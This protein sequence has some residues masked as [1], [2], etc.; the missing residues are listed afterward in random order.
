V[1]QLQGLQ[2]FV[3][4]A[5]LSCHG[6]LTPSGVLLIRVF[7][8][9]G[10][11]LYCGACVRSALGIGRQRIAC[12]RQIKQLQS[13]QLLSQMTKTNV[14]EKCLAEFVIMPDGTEKSFKTWWKTITATQ[15]VSVRVP[16]S[17]HGIAGKTSNSAKTSHAGFFTVHR[18]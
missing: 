1:L 5:T 6:M 7:D 11:Y 9:M 16:H 18:C 3:M 15:L 2:A 10:N 12:Q 4:S 13:Q 17:K 14:E 8:S